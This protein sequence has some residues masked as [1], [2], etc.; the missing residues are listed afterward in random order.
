M[1]PD[2]AR[3]QLEDRCLEVKLAG[4]GLRNATLNLA[5]EWLGRLVGAGLLAE[6]EVR[7]RL[8]E[9]ARAAGLRMPEIHATISSGLRSGKQRPVDLEHHQRLTRT[10][11]SLPLEAFAAIAERLAELC[12]LEGQREVTGYLASRRLELGVADA[13][14]L[15]PTH[16]QKPVVSTLAQEFGRDA[17]AQ[18]GLIRRM[19]SGEPELSRFVWPEHRLCV[20]WRGPEGIAQ[21]IE[22]RY[23]GRGDTERRWVFPA[24][25]GAEWPLGWHLLERAEPERHVVIVEGPSDYFAV[26][27]WAFV[28]SRAAAQPMPVAL[29]LPAATKLRPEWLRLLMDRR[30]FVGLDSDEAGEQAS[31]RILEQLNTIGVEGERSRPPA[32]SKDWAAAWLR[33]SARNERQPAAEGRACG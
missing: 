18:T 17:L 33:A 12:P 15:P 27:A 29:A 30:V 16:Q 5:A 23:T 3:A 20:T 11:P 21:T 25:R 31:L 24:Q 32:P 6:L 2:S 9:A 14:A 13:F 26:R 4:S 7:D 19:P 28:R 1:T 8:I 22:R 10:V